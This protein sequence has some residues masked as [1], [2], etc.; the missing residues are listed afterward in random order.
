MPETTSTAILSDRAWAVLIAAKLDL[1]QEADI[2]RVQEVLTQAGV[3]GGRPPSNQH[4]AQV[5]AVYFSGI[6]VVRDDESATTAQAKAAEPTPDDPDHVEDVED[7]TA[8]PVAP[9]HETATAPF[10]FQ[11]TFDTSFTAFATDGENITGKVDSTRIVIAWRIHQGRPEGA[12]YTSRSNAPPR[13]VPMNNSPTSTP[14][15][16][17]STPTPALRSRSSPS[18]T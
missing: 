18:S 15:R 13:S 8:D 1:T 16:P 17:R 10:S 2:V 6:K 4:R 11:H 7:V 5:E 14:T 12:I 9:E 3:S